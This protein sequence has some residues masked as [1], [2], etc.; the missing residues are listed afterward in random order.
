MKNTA[1]KLL[2]AP[3]ILVCAM[4]A[5]G[6][7]S[8]K[9]YWS[10]S[11]YFIDAANSEDRSYSCTF[12]YTFAYDDFG[13]AEDKRRLG[14]FHCIGKVFNQCSQINWRLGKPSNH[15]RTE[16][17]VQLTFCPVY[18]ITGGQ[19]DALSAGGGRCFLTVSDSFPAAPT[20]AMGR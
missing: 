13:V 20:S 2:I 12:S 1:I 4:P 5:F 19:K 15:Q 17:S 18:Q 11:Y 3:A 16:Y 6:A 10:G 7:P 14:Q 8:I 9:S